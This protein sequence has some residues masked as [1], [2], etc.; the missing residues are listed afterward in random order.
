V[1]DDLKIMTKDIT[2]DLAE[3]TLDRMIRQSA[4]QRS[5]R[6]Y[7]RD[8]VNIDSEQIEIVHH[9]TQASKTPDLAA[10]LIEVNVSS[11]VNVLAGYQ[12]AKD[13]SGSLMKP[14]ELKLLL[15]R[16]IESARIF[17]LRSPI[18]FRMST[19]KKIIDSNNT[20]YGTDG[21]KHFRTYTTSRGIQEIIMR[22]GAYFAALDPNNP[23]GDDHT[24]RSMAPRY[25]QLLTLLLSLLNNADLEATS[26]FLRNTYD[27][28]PERPDIELLFLKVIPLTSINSKVFLQGLIP[29]VDQWTVPEHSLLHERE[30][31][32]DFIIS[33][34][35]RGYLLPGTVGD[36]GHS[37]RSWV[38]KW[39]EKGEIP[40]LFPPLC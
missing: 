27:I 10:T 30:V 13:I 22:S 26:A 34:A 29:A 9:F 18:L 4:S 21:E 19:R 37:R 6:S 1:R 3:G 7:S 35:K 5:F 33:L 8:A 20:R 15:D 31:W 2:Q 38:Y 11:L 40:M 12:Q 16:M 32:T 25:L 36:L 14:E 24:Q 17:C 39:P 28:L 23:G